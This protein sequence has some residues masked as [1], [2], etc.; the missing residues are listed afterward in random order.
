M[1][2][3]RAELVMHQV[4]R[5]CLRVIVYFTVRLPIV[6]AKY[7]IVCLGWHKLVKR[8]FT[9]FNIWLLLFNFDLPPSP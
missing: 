3:L 2:E 5:N 8:L 4:P 9:F 1:R 7:E 6:G